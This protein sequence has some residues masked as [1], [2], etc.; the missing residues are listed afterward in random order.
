[1]LAKIPP[2]IKQVSKLLYHLV[3]DDSSDDSCMFCNGDLHNLIDANTIPK[4]SALVV[5]PAENNGRHNCVPNT[6]TIKHFGSIAYI[7]TGDSNVFIK[8][9]SH[10]TK[11]ND[12][13][14]N[15]ALFANYRDAFNWSTAQLAVAI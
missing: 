3:L 5:E 4:H 6:D 7:L 13:H 1:M 15:A 12:A 14:P 10:A 2:P 8:H 9:L 11:V